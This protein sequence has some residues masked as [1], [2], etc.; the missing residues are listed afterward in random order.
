M[1]IIEI[2]NRE[3]EVDEKDL[4]ALLAI[5]TKPAESPAEQPSTIDAVRELLGESMP[6]V[7]GS[8]EMMF[9]RL[10]DDVTKAIQEQPH[11]QAGSADV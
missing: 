10:S 5:L 4:Q 7:L 2:N 1:M 3:V 9:S 11:S 6:R 8:V